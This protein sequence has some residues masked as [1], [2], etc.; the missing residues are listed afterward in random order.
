MYNL[1]YDLTME[2]QI[3][4]STVLMEYLNVNDWKGL[5]AETACEE[6]AQ[7]HTQFY[8]DVSWENE[9]LEKDCAEA[10]AFILNKDSTH[11]KVVWELPGVK[12]MAQRKDEN[13]HAEIETIIENADNQTAAPTSNTG[14]DTYPDLHD[15]NP[16]ATL[17]DAE[18]LLNSN[19]TT[20]AFSL[21]HAALRNFLQKACTN[22]EI[23][24]NQDDSVSVL[25]AKVNDHIKRQ[26]GVSQKSTSLIDTSMSMLRTSTLISETID[27]LSQQNRDES[28]I[29]KA[30][31]KYAI[32]LT[33]S[34]MVYIDDLIG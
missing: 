29:H 10:L 12:T 20:Q 6:F 25:H 3:K 30:D 18:A 28:Q 17:D 1:T 21:M 5:F 24:T 27:D 26:S 22:K 32:N 4:L 14:T 9:T 11:L 2:Q 19:R 7:Q 8:E 23:S 13:F 33:R 16:Y 34:D 31:V 15:Q